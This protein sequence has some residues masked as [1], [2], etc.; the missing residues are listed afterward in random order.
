MCALYEYKDV[1]RNKMGIM[2]KVM[3]VKQMCKC[4][5]MALCF[6]PPPPLKL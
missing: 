4:K 5:T 1:V 3:V 6:M 2:N